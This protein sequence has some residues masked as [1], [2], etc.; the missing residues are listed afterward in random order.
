M[1]LRKSVVTIKSHVY[2]N[3]QVVGL[4]EIRLNESSRTKRDARFL[5]VSALGGRGFEVFFFDC[6]L[7]V[8]LKDRST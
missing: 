6:N 5:T 7:R 1:L 2:A 4:I 8:R 3:L